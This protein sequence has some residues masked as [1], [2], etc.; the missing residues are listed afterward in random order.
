MPKRKHTLLPVLVV[1]FLISYGLMSLLVVEQ[2]RT[3]DAQRNL[4][5]QLFSDSAELTSLKGKALQKQH[6]AAPA[7]PQAE[8]RTQAS[9]EAKAQ[10]PPSQASPRDNAKSEHRAGKL[11][12]LLPP[13]PPRDAADDS[14][15]RRILFFI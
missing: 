15:E 9:P 7:P 4:I 10:T 11:R 12:R 6:A 2:G 1:L 8:G 3:I 14:D 5:R 13:K